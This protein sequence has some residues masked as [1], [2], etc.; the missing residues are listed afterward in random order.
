MPLYMTLMDG[1]LSI[2][3]RSGD[4]IVLGSWKVHNKTVVEVL[5]S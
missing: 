4:S 2:K 5:D 3:R 1:K